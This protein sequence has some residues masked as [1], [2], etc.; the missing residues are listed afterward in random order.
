VNERIDEQIGALLDGRVPEP[1]R[2]ELLALLAA[3]DGDYEVFAD[4]AAVLRE[5]EEEG[6][7]GKESA[8]RREVVRETEV[9][10]LRPRRAAGWRSPPARWMALAAAVAALALFPVL[11]SRMNAEGW[12]NPQRLAVLAS[13]AGARLPAE[14]GHA[15]NTTRGGGSESVPNSGVAAQVGALH[16]DMEVA[17]RASDPVVAATVAQLARTAALTLEYAADTGPSWASPEYD[18]IA[19][20]TDWARPRVLKRLASARTEVLRYVDRDYFA[21]GAWTEA[22]RLAVRRQDTAFFG[23]AESR[24]AVARAVALPGLSGDTKAAAER[25]GAVQV[26]GTIQ[27]WKSLETYLDD[28]Q[29]GLSR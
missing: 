22:A 24:E 20:L 1:R 23:T 29:R 21:V 6:A 28:L 4:T 5:A 19:R 7:A 26:Q 18:E 14:W 2:S 12:R 9:I 11:R 16:L 17:A 27:D 8:D 10:P 13:P 3:D 15:W 25:V